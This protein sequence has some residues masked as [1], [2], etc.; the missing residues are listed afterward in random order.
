MTQ[1]IS[2]TTY[3]LALM[4]N[5][6]DAFNSRD[7]AAMKAIHHPYMIAHLTGSSVPTH[8]EPA[9]AAVMNEML[10]IFPDVHIHNNPY[11]IQLGSGEWTT[12]I[13]RATGTFAGEMILPDCKKIAPTGKAFDVN[14]CTIAKW[15]GDRLLEEYVFWDSA[16][17]AQQIGLS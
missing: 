15:D 1:N 16:L 8:G 11:P 12:V 10:R 6:D 7:V 13:C 3:L 5:G 17:Q 4:K 2:R 9:H 14:F